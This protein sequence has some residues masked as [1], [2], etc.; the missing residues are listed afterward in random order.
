MTEGRITVWKEFLQLAADLNLNIFLSGEKVYW[1]LKHIN[2]TSCLFPELRKGE[3]LSPALFRML[4]LLRKGTG[5]IFIFW[6]KI[7]M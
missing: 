3:Q 2:C 5:K 7:L 1:S 4:Q 6:I